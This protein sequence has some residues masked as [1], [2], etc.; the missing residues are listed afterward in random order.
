MQNKAIKKTKQVQSRI[1]MKYSFK[2][3][4]HIVREYFF[5][6]FWG[7]VHKDSV[8]FCEN[9]HFGKVTFPFLIRFDIIWRWVTSARRDLCYDHFESAS[10]FDEYI[11]NNTSRE[12]GNTAW[13]TYQCCISSGAESVDWN[14]VAW[15]KSNTV[16]NSNTNRKCFCFKLA[17]PLL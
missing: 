3:S 16:I 7:R 4:F 14:M 2:S 8:R 9:M 15:V 13:A 10:L 1:C 6:S 17:L 5:T 12:N 11:C